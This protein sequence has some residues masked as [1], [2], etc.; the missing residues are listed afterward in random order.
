MFRPKYLIRLWRNAFEKTEVACLGI[1]LIELVEFLTPIIPF[2]TWYGADM[3]ANF[4]PE[5]L[6]NFRSYN[7]KKIG[8]DLAL[9]AML[10]TTDQFLSAV[11]IVLK[12][13]FDNS[14]FIEVGTED[15]KF[16]Q[17]DVEGVILE[18]RAFDTSYFELYSDDFSL[19]QKISNHFK[20]VEIETKPTSID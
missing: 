19:I 3:D 9:Y 20:K 6:F 7:L 15:P 16:R 12:R 8:D 1:Q 4:I 14:K 10:K 17:I 13:E 5:A 11:F 18:I 2:H